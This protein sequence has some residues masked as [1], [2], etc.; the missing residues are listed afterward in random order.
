VDQFI[1][2]VSNRE[3]AIVV[4]LEHI[5]H[6]QCLNHIKTK[7]QIGYVADGSTKVTYHVL[8]LFIDATQ[9]RKLKS[10]LK[11][12]DS[13]CQ[14]SEKSCTHT[15]THTHTYIYI[16]KMPLCVCVCVCMERKH[17][18]LLRIFI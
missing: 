18:V 15:H 6:N 3:N 12:L 5:V 13:L 8:G 16:L 11:I 4:L 9:C 1:G 17:I 10:S 7:Y 14:Y 2:Q